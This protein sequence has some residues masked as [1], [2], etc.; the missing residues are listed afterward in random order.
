MK[1]KMKRGGT[2]C[3]HTTWLSILVRLVINYNVRTNHALVIDQPYAR[4]NAYFYSFVPHTISAWNSLHQLHV[5]AP[6]VS[7]F[8]STLIMLCLFIATPPTF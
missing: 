7:A 4:R 2:P 8:K 6:S 5:T 1:R 3:M